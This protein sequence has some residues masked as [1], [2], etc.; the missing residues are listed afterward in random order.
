MSTETSTPDIQAPIY[1]ADTISTAGDSGPRGAE[2]TAGISF[3]PRHFGRHP[4]PTRGAF[5]TKRKNNGLRFRT[6]EQRFR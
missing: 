2:G 5:G 3:K 6:I 1:N 4:K